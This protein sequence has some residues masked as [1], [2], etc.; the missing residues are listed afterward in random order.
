MTLQNKI[1]NLEKYVRAR[2]PQPRDI[3][4]RVTRIVIAVGE[5]HSPGRT[6]E[7]ID[8]ID[9]ITHAEWYE[10]TNKHPDWKDPYYITEFD[11]ALA[12]KD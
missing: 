5:S 7:P 12:W 3:L 6:L 1:T 10:F 8:E 11:E 9:K 4:T 2:T